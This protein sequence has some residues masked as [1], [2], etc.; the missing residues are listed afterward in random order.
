M[1]GPYRT[2]GLGAARDA[3]V[4]DAASLAMRRSDGQRD[5]VRL[6]VA[7]PHLDRHGAGRAEIRERRDDEHH[8]A[9]TVAADVTQHAAVEDHERD[10][11]GNVRPCAPQ[12]H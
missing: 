12:G 1:T 7:G 5:R 9:L 10:C 11:G 3:V 8:A 6:T 4:P 2:T